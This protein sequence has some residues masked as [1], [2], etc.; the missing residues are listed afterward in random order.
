MLNGVDDLDN[1]EV[2]LVGGDI[3]K[4]AVSLISARFKALK[5]GRLETNTTADA[6]SFQ[7][8]A[9]LSTYALED[10]PLIAAFMRDDTAPSVSFT[11]DQND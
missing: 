9:A 10:S 8:S 4:N 11:D 1:A 3:A 2:E 7:K 5:A 6:K